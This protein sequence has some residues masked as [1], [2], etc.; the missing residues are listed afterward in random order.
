M[1]FFPDTS[2]LCALYREQDNSATARS[3]YQSLDGP[4]GISA[5]VG[6]E[7]RQSV[8]LQVFLNSRDSTKGYRLAEATRVLAKF[9]QNLAAG[10]LVIVPV[11]WPEVLLIA[12][13]ISVAH[14]IQGG[15]RS[16]DVLHVATALQLGSKTLLS[17]DHRQRSL[18]A[19]KGLAISP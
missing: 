4:L 13:R 9:A 10:A 16:W 19:A 8:R 17:F 6:F 5:A 14:T 7:F 15:H 3:F 11:D 18:A 2:F 12:E 1:N